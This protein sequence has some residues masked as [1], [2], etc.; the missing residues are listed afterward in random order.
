MDVSCEVKRGNWD[1]CLG[2]W[3]VVVKKGQIFLEKIKFIV[4]LLIWN[5]LYVFD[6]F[7]YGDHVNTHIFAISGQIL[8]LNKC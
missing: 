5:N 8:V 7:S 2:D 3:E 4:D 1:F 6:K